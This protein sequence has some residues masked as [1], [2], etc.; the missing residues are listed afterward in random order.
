MNLNSLGRRL[1]AV[2]KARGLT[3]REVEDMLRLPRTAVTRIEAGRRSVS[4]LELSRLA[5]IYHRPAACFLGETEEDA[6][7]GEDLL[8]ALRSVEP[9][10]MNDRKVR[11]RANRCVNLCLEGIALRSLLGLTP[12][13]GPPNYRINFPG[14]EGEA[15]SRGQRAMER[16]R[17]RM[18]VSDG[19]KPDDD[20]LES[21]K[22]LA[23]KSLYASEPAENSDHPEYPD[24]GLRDEIA[25]LAVE[26]YRRELISRG[27]LMDLGTILEIHGE[28]LLDIAERAC[29]S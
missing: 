14:P 5:R 20:E 10:L 21:W 24:R 18:G 9:G 23:E 15:V 26:A 22:E 1:M 27:R 25:H 11:D 19:P 3:R 2:R 16:E 4:T 17:R 6:D 13:L 12:R 29:D 8:L 7:P 28:T